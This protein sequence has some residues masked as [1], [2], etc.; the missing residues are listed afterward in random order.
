MTGTFNLVAGRRSRGPSKCSGSRSAVRPLAGSP[1]SGGH[2][3]GHNFEPAQAD[4]GH[5]SETPVTTVLFRQ[6]AADSSH[7]PRSP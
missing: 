2:K 4:L 3:L 5:Q 7:K 1:N 6:G